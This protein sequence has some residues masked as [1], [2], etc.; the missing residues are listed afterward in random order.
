MAKIRY[1]TGWRKN[2]EAMVRDAIEL[3]QA[4]D[5]LPRNVTPEKRAK[6]ICC[7]AY[8]GKRLAGISTIDIKPYEPL[9]NKR[10]GFLRVFTQPDYEGQEIAVGLAKECRRVLEEWSIAN[11]DEKLAGMAAIYQSPKL[12]K[13][14][15]GQSGLTLVGY[16][17]E[18]H[19]VVVIWF[20]HLPV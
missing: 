4:H 11:P 6:E 15:V 9:R 18:G 2:D 8:D 19:Q 20:N 10:F 7:L 5:I 1:V 12:G 17:P 16:T 3:W 14:P 13:Y